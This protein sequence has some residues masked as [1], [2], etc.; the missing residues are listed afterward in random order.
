MSKARH[1]NH[2]RQEN[3]SCLFSTF[4]FTVLFGLNYDCKWNRHMFGCECVWWN[5]PLLLRIS[6]PCPMQVP[7]LCSDIST[8]IS[9]LITSNTNILVEATFPVR[10]HSGIFGLLQEMRG[11]SVCAR[12]CQRW[13]TRPEHSV[14]GGG[15]LESPPLLGTSLFWMEWTQGASLPGITPLPIC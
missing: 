1:K 5:F 9:F 6:P 14:G 2:R 10:P 11:V 8:N 4:T 12:S 7:S 13:V 3:S 15:A